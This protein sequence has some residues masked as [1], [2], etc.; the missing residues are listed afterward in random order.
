MLVDYLIDILKK[1]WNFECLRT[2]DLG[3]MQARS[4]LFS[5]KH[6]NLNKFP[7]G[8]ILTVHLGSI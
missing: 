7:Y 5:K 1:A 2:W 4:K 8:D 3:Q 6:L